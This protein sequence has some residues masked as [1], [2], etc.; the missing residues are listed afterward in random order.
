MIPGQVGNCYERA[1]LEAHLN[2]CDGKTLGE[3]DWHGDFAR[4]VVSP[5]INGIAGNVIEH[6]VLHLP[7]NPNQEPDIEVDGKTFEVKTTGVRKSKKDPL[8]WE[9]KEPMTITAVSPKKIVLQEYTT[10]AFWHKIERM[11]LFYY[12]Y[13]SL[14]AVPALE[15]KRFKLLGHEFHL[16]DGFTPEQ[17]LMLENDWRHVRDFIIHLNNV[18]EK[19][20]DEYPRISHDLRKVL[21]LLDTAPK[22]PHP[23][24]FRFK[25]SF[26]SN[27]FRRFAAGEKAVGESLPDTFSSRRE[28]DDRCYELEQIYRGKTVSELCKTLGIKRKKNEQLK[29]IAELVIVRMFGGKKAKKMNQVRE[30]S[31]IGVQGKSFVVT[32]DNKR[33]E[34]AKF[35][36]IDF[37]EIA[38]PKLEFEDSQFYEFFSSTRIL[39]AV[40]EEPNSKSP[41]EKNVFKH[42]RTITFDDEFIYGEVKPV[43]DKIRDLVINNKL[44]DEPVLDGHGVQIVNKNGELRS[45]PNLPKSSEGLVF[46]RGTGSDS[47]DKRE[48]VN[49]VRMYHQ[50]VWIKGSYIAELVSQAF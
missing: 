3:L 2:S 25:R 44:V 14:K 1:S 23:P 20:E 11:L 33:T 22:W 21:L 47:K 10:S 42:F 18:S 49:G 45:A 32:K 15:Y 35:F 16:Y 38:D 30:F 48:S 36:T 12:H 43:W 41:L 19:P 39:V 4:A 6:S 34:D 37:D 31:E 46:V 7:D 28:F 5:R 29:S 26:V 40:F 50:Q 9:A 8:S 13:D 17:R 24:R 27:I